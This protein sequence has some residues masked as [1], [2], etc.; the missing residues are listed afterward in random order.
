MLEGVRLRQD[1][2]AEEGGAPEFDYLGEA[3]RMTRTRYPRVLDDPELLEGKTLLFELI[4]PTARQVTNYG[5]RADLIFLA[6]FDHARRAYLDHNAVRQ[7]AETHGLTVVEVLAPR[8]DDLAT[9]IDA[10][11]ASWAGTDEE[12]CVLSFERAG[13][14]VYRVKVK[15]PDYL[16]L[17]RL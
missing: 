8:G 11:L 1:D 7:L 5:E 6:C 12:G 14:V 4:H 17:M 3:R 13:E 15:S 9:Q 2:E 10:L 16:Q